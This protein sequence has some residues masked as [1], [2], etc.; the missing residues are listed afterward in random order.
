[1]KQGAPGC[2]HACVRVR[3]FVWNVPACLR[4]VR[5]VCAS[6]SPSVEMVIDPVLGSVGCRAPTGRRIHAS[7]HLSVHASV[8]ASVGPLNRR[9]VRTVPSI[10]ASVNPSVCFSVRVSVRVSVRASV[11]PCYLRLCG[12]L[13]DRMG[14]VRSDV[15]QPVSPFVYPS[16]CPSVHPSDLPFILP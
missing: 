5:D 13:Q 1:M 6:V 8:R 3:A 14:P 4:D 12:I 16:I 15:A 10:D 7:V 2:V 11:C 9:T